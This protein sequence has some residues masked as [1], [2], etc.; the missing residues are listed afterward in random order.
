MSDFNNKFATFGYA[1]L[2]AS[3]SFAG[4]T[5]FMLKYKNA[6]DV[7]GSTP[8]EAYRDGSDIIMQSTTPPQD[9]VSLQGISPMFIP[10]T[11]AGSFLSA[12]FAQRNQDWD[13]AH[14]Y[15]NLLK[16]YD[17][18]DLVLLR[19]HMVSSMAAGAYDDGFESA[20]QLQ[21]LEDDNPLSQL[22]L[23]VKDIKNHDYTEALKRAG[24]LKEDPV[25][26]F[27]KTIL[28]SWAKAGTGEYDV[29]K[30]RHN[31]IYLHHAIAISYFL[32]RKDEAEKLMSTALKRADLQASDLERIA[33][34]YAVM[35]DTGKAVNLYQ[36]LHQLLPQQSYLLEKISMLENSEVEN[37]NKVA[38]FQTPEQGVS[39]ALYDTAVLL[40]NEF[41]DDS[42]AIFLSMALY[43]NPDLTQAKI[44]SASI[45][46]RQEHFSDAIAAYLSIKESS[47]YFIQ[48]RLQAADVMEQAGLDEQ[49]L[50]LLN[51]LAQNHN[52]L[53]ARIRLGDLHRRQKNFAAAIEQYNIAQTDMGGHVS[54][55]Y[56]YLLYLRGMAYERDGQWEKAEEDL[57]GALQYRPNDPNVLNY[58]GYS[59]ADRG[60]NLDK[61]LVM[62]R[63]AV[64]LRPDDGYITDSL[65]W[66]LYRIGQPEDAIPYLERAIQLM[67]YDAIINDHLGDAY[68]QVGRKLEARFQWQRA[69]N[70][71]D[72]DESKEELQKQITEKLTNGLEKIQRKDKLEAQ[73][74][75]SGSQL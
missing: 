24:A 61:A 75:N 54:S 56:W 15:L 10:D 51:D 67:P 42:A 55:D 40:Y 17:E 63:Q 18:Q 28:Q 38:Q 19:R 41:S 71:I 65:G 34:L 64:R 5:Y 58:L 49:A 25:S 12:L 52:A 26:D 21:E 13:K 22:F 48:S 33:D 36:E 1:M 29:K 70:N 4:S 8:A 3:L 6:Q 16:R 31:T 60:E 7:S 35:G 66:V 11:Q 32:D 27:F 44:L 62:I 50:A 69:L 73:N 57:L 47:P 14:E 37:R 43:L 74:L 20:R 46:T 30:L 2:I 39:L 9:S 23:A 68:W 53:E 45:A 72:E 59:W